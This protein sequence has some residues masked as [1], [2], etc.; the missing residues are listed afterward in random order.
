MVI[1]LEENPAVFIQ[2]KIKAREKRYFFGGGVRVSC[3][4][5]LVRVGGRN[6]NLKD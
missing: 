3:I 4:Y 2:A 6:R 1:F 5:L